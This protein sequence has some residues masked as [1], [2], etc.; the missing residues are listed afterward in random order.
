V[1]EESAT[2]DAVPEFKLPL[3]GADTDRGDLAP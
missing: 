2:V 1:L 3:Y